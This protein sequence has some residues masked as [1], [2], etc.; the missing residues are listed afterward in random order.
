MYIE[1]QSHINVCTFKR[2]RHDKADQLVR[3]RESVR[4]MERVGERKTERVRRRKER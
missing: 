4:E 2:M 3:Q 1:T